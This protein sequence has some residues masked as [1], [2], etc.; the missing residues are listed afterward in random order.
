PLVADGSTRRGG[1]HSRQN[2]K[3]MHTTREYSMTLSAPLRRTGL[4]LAAALML[5]VAPMALHAATPDDTLVV[6]D[7]IDDIVSL[8][9]AEAFE[10]SG[11]GVV[12][13]TY[14]ALVEQDPL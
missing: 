14:D 6:A 3:T 2:Q 8:D 5:G 9:P 11:V 10:F 1:C 7:A 12:N 4:S 13:N